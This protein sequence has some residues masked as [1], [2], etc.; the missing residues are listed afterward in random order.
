MLILRAQALRTAN[1]VHGFLGRSGGV[2]KGIYAALNCGPGSKDDPGAIAENREIAVQALAGDQEPALVTCYQIH[3]ANAVTVTEPWQANRSP[4]AD[5]M[6]TNR[7][8]IM[9]GILTADCAPVL[10]ADAKA[11]IIGAAHAGWNGA[12]GG[13]IESAVSAM[14]ALGARRENI[15]AAIGP[16]ISQ[17]A[18]EVG[19]EFKQRFCSNDDSYA[20]FF[21]PSERPGHWQFALEEFVA[22]R[23]NRAGL[24]GIEKLSACTYSGESEFFSYRRATHRAEPDY[25]RQLS[26]I[27]LSI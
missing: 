8:G 5:A 17:A 27:A 18:Y 10:F 2:S 1:I 23:L 11:R 9:L 21:L 15:H 22:D 20:R 6:V 7:A 19:P 25:G 14:T 16:C 26:A 24:G 12:L 13:V 3:S 4:K